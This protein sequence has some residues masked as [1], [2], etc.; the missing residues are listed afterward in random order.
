MKAVVRRASFAALALAGLVAGCDKLGLDHQPQQSAQLPS[1][2]ALQRIGYMSRG[3]AGADGRRLFD[4]LE[5]ARSCAD[6]ELAMRWNRPPDVQAG[7]FGQKMVYLTAGIPA[8]LPKQS[9]VFV[10]GIIKRGEPLSSGS[11]G[12]SVRMRDGAEVQ[13]I[14][15]AEYR[16]KQEQIQQEGGG[17]A[18]V[19]PYVPGRA[20]CGYGIYQGQIGKALEGN[21]N[22]PL[23]SIL[24]ALDRK[25]RK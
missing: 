18:F 10:S 14:E 8:D 9:E 4:H 12:W 17:A 24:F 20:F 19:Q 1:P 23:V 13:A 3:P 11:S 22:V 16:Q 5:Q 7:P 25:N 2:E 21:A 6:L 15:A